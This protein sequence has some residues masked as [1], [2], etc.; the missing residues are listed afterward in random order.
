MEKVIWI[1]F[2]ILLIILLI[3]LYKIISNRKKN[4]IIIV[5]FIVLLTY[6]VYS[7]F[8]INGSARLS[9]TLYGHP[10]I[11][12]TTGFDDD[13]IRNEDLNN[14]KY[15]LPTKRLDDLSSFFECKSYGPIR[16]T[17]YYGF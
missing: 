14:K 5:F 2:C 10:I 8:T 7:F 4:K 3:M 11:A 9:I 16:I 12:Y 17:T 15:L 6:F 1:I 13:F